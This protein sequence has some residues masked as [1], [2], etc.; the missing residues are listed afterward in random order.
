MADDAAPAAAAAPATPSTA[1][2]SGS[3][4]QELDD[5]TSTIAVSLPFIFS[6]AVECALMFTLSLFAGRISM[7]ALAAVGLN[8]IIVLLVVIQPGFGLASGAS[9]LLAAAF[10]ASASNPMIPKI[11]QRAWALLLVLSVM[12]MPALW[13]SADLLGY[14][15]TDPDVIN[16][17][18][19]LNRTVVLFPVVFLANMMLN[20][21]LVAIKQNKYV[22]LPS[23][24]VIVFAPV[25]LF[26]MVDGLGMGP[27]ALGIAWFGAL[28]VAAGLTLALVLWKRVLA[29]SWQPWT[30]DALSGW[31]ELLKTMVPSMLLILSGWSAMEFYFLYAATFLNACEVATSSVVHQVRFAFFVVAGNYNIAVGVR[32]AHYVGA[33]DM[34]G[35]RRLVKVN[36]VGLCLLIL[37]QSTLLLNT[38]ELVPRLFSGEACVYE[39][40]HNSILA[41]VASQSIETVVA[42]HT[43]VLRSLDRNTAAVSIVAVAW[44]G[45][46]SVALV[47]L[48]HLW[49]DEL[50][51]SV[52]FVAAAICQALALGPAIY[53]LWFQHDEW[54]ITERMAAVSGHGSESSPSSKAADVVS[55]RPTAGNAE[56]EV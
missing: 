28:C 48:R 11:A 14:F 1:A 7:H 52:V 33:G 3:A 37:V 42:F 25:A 13:H 30:S 54:R 23:A 55:E 5:L 47:T 49:A 45:V 50:R 26:I 34:A 43:F 27:Q 15:G 53:T 9:P 4:L 8:E 10:G 41:L 56:R 12:M 31:G 38:I 36:L 46:G 32:V 39:T 16:I 29:E 40:Y 18:Q 21:Y 44:W 22:T 19:L 24:A 6:T 35:A 17:T 2:V 51:L 20:Q